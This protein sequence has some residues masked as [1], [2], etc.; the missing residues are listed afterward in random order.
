MQR[1]LGD[2]FRWLYMR[3]HPSLWYWEI[4]LLIRRAVTVGFL[5]MFSKYVIGQ[6]S[7]SSQLSKDIIVSAFLICLG[8][9]TLCDILYS[10]SDTAL[11]PLQVGIH[12]L[13]LISCVCRNYASDTLE[14]FILMLQFICQFCLFI[15]QVGIAS[16]LD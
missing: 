6:V 16:V 9:S 10:D 2:P 15:Y 1:R 3:F 4:V 14:S 11:A 12:C 8:H 7:A 5:V 13:D